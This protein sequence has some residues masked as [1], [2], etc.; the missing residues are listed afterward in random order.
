MRAKSEEYGA[1]PGEVSKVAPHV[2][3]RER[4]RARTAEGEA[5][6]EPHR[7]PSQSRH[8]D[9]DKSQCTS[10]GPAHSHKDPRRSYQD[11]VDYMTPPKR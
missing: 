2:P 1:K 5:P 6:T 11:H 7:S 10:M 8:N 9:I 3:R 4:A